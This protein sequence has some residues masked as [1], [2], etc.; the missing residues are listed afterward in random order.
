[1]FCITTTPVYDHSIFMLSTLCSAC[2]LAAQEPTYPVDCQAT[3][4]RSSSTIPTL[5]I[6]IPV[7]ISI[8]LFAGLTAVVWRRMRRR[9][10]DLSERLIVTQREMDRM[11]KAWEIDWSEITSSAVIGEGAMGE[12]WQGHWR[13]MSVAVKVLTGVYLPLEQLREEMDREATMLQTLRHAHVV[14]FLGAGT[15]DQGMPFLLTELM[16]LGALTD[17]LRDR[18]ASHA[19]EGLAHSKNNW[20]VHH[21]DWFTK[22]RFAQEI[23]GGMAL[24]HSLG[25]MHRDL[26]SGNVLASALGGSV[27]LKVADFGTATLAGLASSHQNGTDSRQ[28]DPAPASLVDVREATLTLQQ[29]TH[30]TKGVGTPLWMAP[31]VMAGRKYGPSADVYSYA[32]LLWEIASHSVPWEHVQGPFFMEQLRQRI[33]AGERPSVDAAWPSDFVSI[34]QQCWAGDVS[35]RPSFATVVTLLANFEYR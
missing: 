4:A 9:N 25:R 35:S 34:M 20:R 6:V 7:V 2:D 31:E 8:V 5:Q 16:E 18:G 21:S 17:L 30:L 22:R 1:M 32:I 29:R 28:Q 10:E 15:N 23:A 24:V 33:E 13:G 12:V 19:A 26:K 11:R 14:Q 27:R 3:P